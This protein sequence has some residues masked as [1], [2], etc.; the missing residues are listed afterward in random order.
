MKTLF[1]TERLTV[2]HFC[3]FDIPACEAWLS[4][5]EVMRWIEEPFDHNQIEE[6]LNANAFLREPR[7]Y[8]VQEKEGGNLAGHLIFHPFDESGYELGWILKKEAWHKGYASELTEAAVSFAKEKGIRA[9]IIE[10][11]RRQQATVS[12]AE[13]CGFRL[14]GTDGKL[15]CFRRKT[16]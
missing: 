12:L 1:A 10:C 13:H 6:F 9:L 4:D 2:R 16:G 8:A 3:S 11:D 14:S 15:L 7:V 5:P